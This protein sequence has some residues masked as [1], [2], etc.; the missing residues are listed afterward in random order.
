MGKIALELAKFSTEKQLGFLEIKPRRILETRRTGR[1]DTHQYFHLLT[2]F[3][4]ISLKITGIFKVKDVEQNLGVEPLIRDYDLIED[5]EILDCLEADEKLDP[6]QIRVLKLIQGAL[7]LSANALNQDSSQLV[8]QLWGRLQCFK[9]PVI[10]KLLKDAQQSN[11]KNPRFRPITASLNRPNIYLIRTFT[12]HIFGVDSVAMTFDG[13][14]AI[15]ACSLNPDSLILWDLETGKIISTFKGH[16]ECGD[17]VSV[18]SI[19]PDNKKVVSAYN[20][21]FGEETL[22]VCNLETGENIFFKGHK[23][24]VNAVSITPDS[25]K[26]ISA[27]N[28]QTL[29]LWNLETGENIF[30]LKGHKERVNAVSITPDGK[31]AI[32]A[33]DDQTLILWDLEKGNKIFAFTHKTD[34]CCYAVSSDGKKVVV[35][36][37]KMIIVWDLDTGKKVFTFKGH[38]E[39]I[40]AAAITPDD[41]KVISASNDKTLILWDLDTGEKIYSFVGHSA[42]I[43]TVVITPDGKKA[44]SASQDHT[45]KLW[46]LN[47]HNSNKNSTRSQQSIFM[48]IK[49]WICELWICELFK[50]EFLKYYSNSHQ[51]QVNAVA[52]TSDSKKVV[53]ASD[54]ETLRLWDIETGKII[55]FANHFASVNAVAITPDNKKVLSASGERIG[56]IVIRNREENTL[57]LWELDTWKKISTFPGYIPLITEIA[58]TP[59]GEKAVSAS[60]LGQVSVWDT[61]KAIRVINAPSSATSVAITR[62]GKK[63]FYYAAA[64]KTFKVLDLDT[65]NETSNFPNYNGYGSVSAVAVAPDGKKALFASYNIL[66]LWSF[67]TKEKIHILTGHKNIISTV[68]ITS[69]S[70]KAFSGDID[71]T[72]KLWNLETGTEV[73]SFIGDSPIKCCAVSHDSLTIVAGDKLGRV[74]FLRLEGGI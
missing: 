27:S 26:A 23:E 13:K 28:D 46:D 36:L 59:D 49:R 39:S 34:I 64:E 52:I 55:S 9:E 7:R 17:V 62:D 12:G 3:D 74:H 31:K 4:F 44:L 24:L 11:S 57:N 45:L 6:E 32:S 37:G 60:E 22:G 68:A 41:K 40:N 10:Q 51:N 33:S 5:P 30:T 35:S 1:I 43:N 14:K 72:L 19:T 29:I 38:K 70:K 2:D 73:S 15:S 20:P 58:I 25:K 21:F 56:K 61:E 65:G 18:L 63:A 8:G 50:Q 67:E 54:D 16:Q 48:K 47:I 66:E 71:N 53:S 69:D 42:E